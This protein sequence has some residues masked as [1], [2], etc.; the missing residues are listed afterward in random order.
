MHVYL[1]GAK[2]LPVGAR[3]VKLSPAQYGQLVE[4][5]TESFRRNADGS[6]IPIPNVA[7]GANDAFF[8]ARGR[9]SL[10]N[11]CNSWV[12]RAMQVTGVR[13]GWFTPLP[14]TVFLHLPDSRD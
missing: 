9:Y 12:G 6:L 3:S 4:Y 8:E 7:Y 14:K 2:A 13:T 10:F 11:T 5:I 1:L